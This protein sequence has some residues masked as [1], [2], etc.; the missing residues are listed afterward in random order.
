MYYVLEAKKIQDFL[1]N[2]YGNIYLNLISYGLF[3]YL[4]KKG[5]INEDLIL[6]RYFLINKGKKNYFLGVVKD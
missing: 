2:H 3:D 6:N 1:L 5:K 4:Y